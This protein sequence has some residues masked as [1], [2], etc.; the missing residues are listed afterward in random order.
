MASILDL[1]AELLS[2]ICQQ[3][4][5]SD[6]FALRLSCKPLAHRTQHYFMV[7]HFSILFLLPTKDNLALLHNICNHPTCRSYVREL[8]LQPV[9]LNKCRMTLDHFCHSDRVYLPEPGQADRYSLANSH[10]NAYMAIT[11]EMIQVLES[12]AFS[13]A[14]QQALVQLPGLTAVR[15]E[16][17]CFRL[18]GL[19]ADQKPRMYRGWK[20]VEDETGMDPRQPHGPFGPAYGGKKNDDDPVQSALCLFT[21]LKALVHVVADSGPDSIRHI[22]T[23]DVRAS[24]YSGHLPSGPQDL[25]LLEPFLR[26]LEH[27]HLNLEFAS[28]SVDLTAHQSFLDLVKMGAPR[29]TSFTYS[30]DGRPIP[31]CLLEPIWPSIQFTRLLKLQLSTIYIAAEL[32]IEFLRTTGPTLQSFDLL[33]VCLHVRPGPEWEQ[34][35]EDVKEAWR[36]LWRFFRDEMTAL[37]RV[38]I[39]TLGDEYL[40]VVDPLHGPN[41]AH[42]LI[43]GTNAALYDT[44]RAQVSLADWIDQLTF[45]VVDS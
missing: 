17:D 36:S 7:K 25:T 33:D 40:H 13:R 43:R 44:A 22:K 28:D 38:L 4:G 41:G 39:D 14:L 35:R 3:L 37:R 24:D 42:S 9:L 10:Y 16:D 8:W 11:L 29:L 5:S 23:V 30:E 2:L 19:S 6:I 1:P 12:E 20:R 18:R 27:L 15:I 31:R 26:N 21:L 45:E 32:L 34:P